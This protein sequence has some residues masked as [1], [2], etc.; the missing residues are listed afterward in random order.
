MLPPGLSL[1]TD[2]VISGT[3]TAA[4][5]S[6]FTITVTDKKSNAGSQP[7]TIDIVAAEQPQPE[8]PPD[9]PV[10]RGH[11]SKIFERKHIVPITT[12]GRKYVTTGAVTPPSYTGPGDLYTFAHWYGLRAYSAAKIGTPAIRVFDKTTDPSNTAPFDLVTKAD[13]SLDTTPC[14]ISGRAL[15]DEF[16]LLTMY[17]Q[18]AATP[19]NLVNT[20]T[21]TTY[22]SPTGKIASGAPAGRLEAM[23]QYGANKLQTG[24]ITTIAQPFVTSSVIRPTDPTGGNVTWLSLASDDK[25][26]S[27]FQST[28]PGWVGFSANYDGV[29]TIETAVTFFTKFGGAGPSGA[30][31]MACN[32]LWS[33]T[34]ENL[35]VISP[36]QPSGT[37]TKAGGNIGSADGATFLTFLGGQAGGVQS[38]GVEIGILPAGTQAQVTALGNNQKAFWKVDNY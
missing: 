26:T 27:M 35:N 36:T 17:D 18:A 10:A 30:E 14:T 24:T 21:M 33:Y 8:P 5:S 20:G 34:A 2:G 23:A 32:F 22:F 31:P 13:G 16:D 4:G 38:L 3:P 19:A 6:S 7:Y 1:S 11:Q 12:F 28:D 37:T 29:S 25:L 9:F 15:T